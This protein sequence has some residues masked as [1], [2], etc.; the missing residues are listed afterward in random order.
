MVVYFIEIYMIK[1]SEEMVLLKQQERKQMT[2]QI[3]NTNNEINHIEEMMKISDTSKKI[4]YLMS[5]GYAVKDIYKIFKEQKITTKAGG[6]IRYQHVR[7]V[8]I[9][10][11]TSK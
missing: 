1:T 6:E 9:T 3:N 2:K 4:R 5:N 10:P 7:N 8:A 11:L